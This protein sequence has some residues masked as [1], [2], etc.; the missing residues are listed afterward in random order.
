MNKAHAGAN[1]HSSTGFCKRLEA[2]QEDVASP[3][4]KEIGGKDHCRPA[5]SVRVDSGRPEEARVFLLRIDVE[6][7]RRQLTRAVAPFHGNIGHVVE[8]V[9]D[10]LV[11]RYPA[12]DTDMP[13]VLL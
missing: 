5:G 1:L 3:P 9:G 8:V 13:Q 4:G 2:L 7:F 11:L 6:A 10:E 12:H